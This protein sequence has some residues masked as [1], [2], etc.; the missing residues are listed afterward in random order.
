[1]LEP[2]EAGAAGDQAVHAGRELTRTADPYSGS[3]GGFGCFTSY[4]RKSPNKLWL[5]YLRVVRTC[6]LQLFCA[7][8]PGD[9]RAAGQQYVTVH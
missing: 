9:L 6:Y 1:M 2:I 4:G 5:R 8:G 3:P 7:R